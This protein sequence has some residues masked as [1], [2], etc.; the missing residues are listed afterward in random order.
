MHKKPKHIVVLG[1]G[2]AGLSAAWKLISNGCKVTIIDQKSV[3]G[4]LGGTTEFKGKHGIYRF[5]YGGHRF[6]THNQ[7][8]LDL[9]EDLVGDDLLHARRKSVIRFQGR[10]YDYPLAVGNLLK[11]APIGLLAGGLFDL[12]TSP[13]RPP[14]DE[15]FAHWIESRFGPTL[16]KTFF[17]GYT[18]KLWGID[19][20][21]LSSDWAEQRISILDLKDIARRLLMRE[22]NTPRT[23]S[24]TYRYP[25]HGFGVIFNRLEDRIKQ[26]GG[27]F[28]YGRKVLSIETDKNK[29][30]SL[31][32]GDAHISVDQVISTLGL[33]QMVRLTK[34]ECNLKYRGLRFFC[35]MMAQD[36]ISDNTWQYLSD[37]EILATRL[38]EPK[39]RSSFMAP[40]GH[41]SL[42]LEIPCDPGDEIW[43]LS[44]DDLYLRVRSDLKHLGHDVTKA[45]GE[46]FSSY[47][48]QAYPLMRV[49]YEKDR[50]LAFNHIT[51]F[52]NLIQCGRQGTFRYIFTDTAMETGFMAAQSLLDGKDR[53]REIFDH[54]NE[55]II[56]ET[57]NVA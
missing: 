33:P 46:Y 25:K 7:D 47:A 49:G 55:A 42:M 39:R 1:A 17:E 35:M 21:D 6:I 57:Q 50:D 54:R 34:G 36:N 40:K 41:T 3:G 53:R 44:D 43:T 9:V 15:S 30:A 37:P 23:Y 29:I 12:L 5:D 18:A 56:I 13:L 4:G 20:H 24:R 45:T 14:R 10:T 2:P 8:L 31:V 38:Q 16:Y 22:D 27:E 11:T 52:D 19:P 26:M 28:L 48:P 32:C 51:R